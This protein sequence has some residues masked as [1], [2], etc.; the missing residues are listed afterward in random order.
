MICRQ[1]LRVDSCSPAATVRDI[2][3]DSGEGK[4]SKEAELP[5]VILVVH[6]AYKENWT[7]IKF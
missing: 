1:H 6:H 7:D 2:L 4:S 5:A 3:K